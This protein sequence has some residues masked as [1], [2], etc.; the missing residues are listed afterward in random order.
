MCIL[1]AETVDLIFSQ[2]S[3]LL[4]IPLALLAGAFAVVAP[5]ADRKI[6]HKT[7]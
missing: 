2:C 3:I 4:S 7:K 1:M 5:D 6:R